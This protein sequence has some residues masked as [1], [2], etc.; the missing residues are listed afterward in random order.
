MAKNKEKARTWTWCL[1]HANK[2][3]LTQQIACQLF[4][5]LEQF[6][7]LNFMIYNPQVKE[8]H[9]KERDDKL[10]PPLSC[11]VLVTDGVPFFIKNVYHIEVYPVCIMV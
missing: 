9:R 11:W 10:L 7:S 4:T 5:I 6:N 1:E 2:K 8:A 3:F